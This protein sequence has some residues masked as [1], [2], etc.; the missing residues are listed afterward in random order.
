MSLH[1]YLGIACLWGIVTNNYKPR[2]I[3]VSGRPRF[4]RPTSN[5]QTRLLVRPQRAQRRQG[6]PQLNRLGYEIRPCSIRRMLLDIVTLGLWHNLQSEAS[7]VLHP[8]SRQTV[9]TL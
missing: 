6:I 2:S 5:T 1:A 7:S 4:Y 3:S 9:S 8:S